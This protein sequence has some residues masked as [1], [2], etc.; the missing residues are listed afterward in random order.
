[1]SR[2]ALVKEVKL[3]PHLSTMLFFVVR[4][5]CEP[6]ASVRGLSLDGSDPSLSLGCKSLGFR[7]ELVRVKGLGFRVSWGVSMI[8]PI[9]ASVF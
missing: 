8:M 6:S 9:R 4:R 3:Y 7:V 1:M 5:G 2:F